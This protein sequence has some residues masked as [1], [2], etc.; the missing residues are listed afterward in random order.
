MNIYTMWTVVLLLAV[1]HIVSS[2]IIIS[3]TRSCKDPN[4]RARDQTYAIIL[5]VLSVFSVTS[6]S[7]MMFNNPPSSDV[8]NIMAPARKLF[9]ITTVKPSPAY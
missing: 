1:F 2:S 3:H 9:P 4:T 6:L 5:L 7:I 8:I